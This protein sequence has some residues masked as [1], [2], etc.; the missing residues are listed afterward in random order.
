[1]LSEY[2]RIE[3]LIQKALESVKHEENPNLA[4][5]AREW[6]VPTRRLR[7]RY[8]GR[9]SKTQQHPRNRALTDSQDLALCQYIDHLDL[10]GHKATLAQIQGAANS[11][12]QMNSNSSI[13]EVS[14]Q[15][16][17]C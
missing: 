9:P 5:L 4:Q 10:G 2:I 11:L 1:M 14:D 13:V 15:W 17:K 6:K 8:K 7:E 16:T 3:N 12:L